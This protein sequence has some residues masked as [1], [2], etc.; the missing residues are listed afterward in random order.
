MFSKRNLLPSVSVLLAGLCI[1]AVNAEDV[2]EN[3]PMEEII[4]TSS[5]TEKSMLELPSA[6]SVV[7]LE[8][9]Q[10]GRQQL[11][12]DESLNRVPGLFSQNRYNFAQD[13]RIAIKGFWLEG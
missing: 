8:D 3:L 9:I 2:F 1:S 5:R 4:V 6:V 13:L 10:V 12:L 7:G 11:G